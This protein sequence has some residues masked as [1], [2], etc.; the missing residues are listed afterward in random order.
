MAGGNL[1]PR[2]K[3]I[4]M[5][6]LVLT[7]LLALN[8]TKEVINAFVTINDSVT[9]SKSNIDKKNSATYSS[10]AQAMSNDPVKYK[11]VNDRAQNIKKSAND[12]VTEIEKIK[13]ELIKTCE[14]IKDGE[15]VP[16]LKDMDRKDDYDIP[17]NIMCGDDHDGKGKKATE[18]RAKFDAFKKLIVA[19]APKG[20]E[21]NYKKS[22]DLTLNTSDPDPKSEAYISEGKRT[23]EM[24]NFYHNPVVAT[25]ALLTKYQNDVRTTESIVI[26]ELLASVDKNIIKLDQLA[27]KVIAP[28]IVTQGTEYRADVFVSATSST[29]Q[30]EVF[31]GATY[32]SV[33]KTMK[34]GDA[35]PLPIENGVGVRKLTAGGEGEQKWGGVIRLKKPDGSYDFFPFNT[36]YIVQK[37][38]A[39][40]AAE[41]MNVLYIGVDNPISVSVPGAAGDKVNASLSGGGGSLTKVGQGKYIAKVTTIGKA[42]IS[43]TAET[44]GKQQNMGSNEF[45]VKRVPDPIAICAGSKGGNINKNALL[46]S[47]VI[48]VLENFDFELFFRTVSFKVSVFRKG[49]DP[50]LDLESNGATFTQA[51]RDAIGG[52]RP[53]DKVYIEYIKARMDKSSD[54][55]V[56]TIPSLAF[57]LQ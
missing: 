24:F 28:S 37:P 41:K 26:D 47:P 15:K 3:M 25:V 36:S 31:V 18:L 4:N 33:S 40:I 44:N 51:Q 16:E 57:T 53:G 20:S 48:P 50:V 56:R 45:R 1:S 42:T 34:G 30:P 32:D 49:K 55:T 46:A 52:A 14:G 43:V 2:Q 12:L 21:D 5:M 10:F 35:N 27:S 13:T 23:W 9:L 11:D 39:T 19:N 54:V 22:L 8:I 38:S 6:Y 29:M 7:A 17:T